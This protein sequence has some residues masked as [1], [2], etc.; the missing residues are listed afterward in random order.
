MNAERHERAVP[1]AD[2]AWCGV[3]FANIVDLLTHV[4]DIHLIEPV[5]AAA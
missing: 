2:C 5:P 4:E 3:E 1:L